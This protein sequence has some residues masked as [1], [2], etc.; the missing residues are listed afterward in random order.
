MN[1]V[2]RERYG[3]LDTVRGA[4]LLNM[5]AYHGLYDLVR[6]MG[7]PMEWY[8]GTP[9]YVWQ[10]AICW[11]FILLSGFCFRLSKR[12]LRHGLTVLGA[13]VAVSIATAVAMPSERI[14][15]GVL[16]LLGLSGL[17]QCGVW[18]LWS[19]LRLP[20]FPAWAGLTLSAAAFF[21]TREVPSG[22]LGFEGLRICP[23]PQW[24]YQWDWLAVL[25]FPG[26]GFWSSDYFPVVP[27]IFLYLCGYF[28]WRLMSPDRRAMDRLRPGIRPLAFL[29]R[30]SLLIYL[31][32]QPALMAVFTAIGWLM[33]R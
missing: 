4:L 5:I 20:P 13:G 12:P 27:W 19:R 6:I 21:L 11:G 33:G 24:L 9:G 8:T 2:S 15:F 29:G 10:Q 3:L 22:Y 16:Y 23:L 32:H 31:L 17:I 25:G 1:R 14:L 7:V 30:H 28:L 18:A 26:P